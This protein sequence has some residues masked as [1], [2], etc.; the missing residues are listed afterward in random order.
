[1]R[2]NDSPTESSTSEVSSTDK[3]GPPLETESRLTQST[4]QRSQSGS[5]LAYRDTKENDARKDG[6]KGGVRTKIRAML[7]RN[8]SCSAPSSPKG[9][10]KQG[11][12]NKDKKVKQDEGKP[13]KA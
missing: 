11:E 2:I 12:K 6:A 13:E 1:L 8:S 4:M 5:S 9:E 3:P 10:R 7:R